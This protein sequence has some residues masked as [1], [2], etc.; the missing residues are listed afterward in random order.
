[1]KDRK[2]AG[3][4]EVPNEIW[5]YCGN[6]LKEKTWI[7]CNTV[8]RGEGWTE[9]RR[10]RIVVPIVKKGKGIKDYR[11]MT[12]MLTLYVHIRYM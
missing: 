8:W 4:D 3:V 5:K 2:A 10:E 9:I 12:L 1:M 11:R 6:E 7:I